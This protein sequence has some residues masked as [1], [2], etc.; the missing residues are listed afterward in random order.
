MRLLTNVIVVILV[1]LGIAELAWSAQYILSPPADSMALGVSLAVLF[2]TLAIASIASARILWRAPVVQLGAGAFLLLIATGLFY[3]AF[4]VPGTVI[5]LNYDGPLGAYIFI[6]PLL[7]LAGG[8]SVLVGALFNRRPFPEYYLLTVQRSGMEPLISNGQ[9]VTIRP[10]VLPKRFDI[11]HFRP[12][13]DCPT[14]LAG[15]IL[16]LPFDIIEIAGGGLIV[17]RSTGEDFVAENIGYSVDEFV[18]GSDEF[19]ILGDNRNNSYDSHDFGPVH[20]DS[21]LGVMQE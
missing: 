11:V 14:E 8:I 4:G 3:L 1:T 2:L 16:G 6:F 7:T 12:P 5:A 15:R 19:F 10:A 21:I 9:T 13:V 17:N 18:L 20:V